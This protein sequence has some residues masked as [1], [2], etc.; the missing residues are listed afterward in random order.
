M[1]TTKKDLKLINDLCPVQK[2]KVMG[3]DG[4]LIEMLAMLDSGSNTSLLS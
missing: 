2:V 4:T 1:L 3:S